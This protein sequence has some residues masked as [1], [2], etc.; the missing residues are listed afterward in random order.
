VRVHLAPECPLIDAEIAPED[1]EPAPGSALGMLQIALAFALRCHGF[2]HLHAAGLVHPSGAGVLLAGGSGAGKT[3][4]TLALLDAGFGSSSVSPPHSYAY[5]GDDSLFLRARGGVASVLA[6]PRAF[7]LGPE[8]LHAF[9]RLRP[10]ADPKAGARGK[11]ALDPRLAFPGR[12][13]SA[14]AAPSVVL[15][16]QIRAE[17]ASSIARVSPADALFSLIGSSAALFIEGLPNHAENLALLPKILPLSG[18]F[19][20]SL[21]RDAL[22]SPALALVPLVERALADVAKS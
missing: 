13:C 3:T 14:M 4:A 12:F 16:P 11:L 8:A 5:L 18:A 22:A 21:G 6:F 19:E 10:L 9:P 2:F 7:H 15:L 1:R 20:L 17:A